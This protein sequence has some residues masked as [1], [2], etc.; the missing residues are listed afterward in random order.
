MSISTRSTYYPSTPK[1]LDRRHKFDTIEKTR[2]YNALDRS[3]GHKSLRQIYHEYAP[4]TTTGHRWR[5]ERTQLGSPS[6][7]RTRK[8]SY[9][10]GAPS[11]VS[12]EV[13]QMLID[14]N[15]NL[16]RDAGLEAQMEF[17]YIETNV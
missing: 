16:V 7:R 5:D 4:S 10:I 8:L 6:Y 1:R 13:A 11:K 17:H 3:R 2:F 12:K 15:Q 9:R 14:P